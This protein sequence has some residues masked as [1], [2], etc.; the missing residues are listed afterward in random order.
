MKKSKSNTQN[1]SAFTIVEL[2]VVIVVIGILAAITI[3]SYVGVQSKATAASLTSDLDNASKILAMD[4]V[5]NSTYPAVLTDANGGKGISASPGTVYTYF[6]S[7][8]GFCITATKSATSYRITNNGT[9]RAG[10]C[11]GLERDKLSIIKWNVW[12]LGTG[13][14]AG[15]NLNGDGNSRLTDINPWGVSD[16]IWDVSNQDAASDAD[17]GWDG[18]SFAID[19]TKMYR[20]STFVKRKTIGNGSFYLGTHG[21]PDAVLSRSSGASNAN[22]YFNATGWWGNANQWYLVVGFV[23]PAGSGTGAA[24][25]DSGVYTMTGTKVMS[26]V[27]FV[28][29]PTTTSSNHRSYLYYSTDVTTNQQWYQPRVDIVDGTEPTITELINNTF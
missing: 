21:Y 11:S 14:V 24:M 5:T 3:V 28:W 27:D 15:Y 23:W 2:L 18:S 9:P 17:G 16:V 8:T 25:A 20:F 29:Q 10:V 1:Q 22:P 26:D 13:S 12:T 6:P 19:N 7:S 4:Q